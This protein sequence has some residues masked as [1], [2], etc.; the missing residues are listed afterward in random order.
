MTLQ[1]GAPGGPPGMLPLTKSTN[2]DDLISFTKLTISPPECEPDSG[3][4]LP[5]HGE[6][7]ST[8]GEFYSKG[9]LDVGAHKQNL[10]DAVSA[11][12]IFIKRM[13]S[14]CL[15]SACPICY[16]KWAGKEAHAIA[17]RLKE[18]KKGRMHLGRV[19]HVVVSLPESDYNLVVQDYSQLKHK[20]YRMLKKVGFFGGS[21]IFHP[22]RFNSVTKEPYFSPHFHILGYGWIRGK[23]VASNSRKTGY[24]IINLGVRDSVVA[25]AQY[26][27]SHAGI[28]SGVHTIT[29]FGAISYNKIKVEPEVVDD[30]VCP[31]CGSELQRV[32]WLGSLDSNP[33][34]DRPEGEYWI[35]PG[36]WGYVVG[37]RSRGQY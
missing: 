12:R 32:E 13:R 2:I 21:M 7:Y 20:I 14:T 8:C 10:L 31:V 22:F 9:C 4:V 37:L 23:K 1:S 24:S 26:Q 3:W 28:K 35:D 5:G 34:G 19:I 30:D 29:W 25:T 15:R 36:G 27:L 18:A 17:Y 11:G 33:L 6:A 16:E